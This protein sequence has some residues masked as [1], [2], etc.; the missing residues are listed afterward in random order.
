MV[1][2]TG[3]TYKYTFCNDLPLHL[4]T[5][6]REQTVLEELSALEDA[7]LKTLRQRESEVLMLEGVNLCFHG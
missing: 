1:T 3:T 2:F 7:E 6:L 5:P 4:Y